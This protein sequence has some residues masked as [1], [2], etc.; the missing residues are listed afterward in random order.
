[1]RVA[2]R[3]HECSPFRGAYVIPVVVSN[4]VSGAKA[5]LESVIDTGFD[6]SIMVAAEA[7]HRLGLE[8]RERPED[9]FPVYRSL[10][11]AF[12]FRRSF[13]SAKL[14]GRDMDVEV[15]TPLHGV[16]KNLIGRR[17]LSQFT[18]LLHREEIACLGEAR[19]ES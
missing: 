16:G 7:Y 9:L 15:V 11:G 4:P 17:V 5:E 2:Y 14:A 1:L 18:T 19:V 10:S 8:L 13:A 12:V 3:E 6:G